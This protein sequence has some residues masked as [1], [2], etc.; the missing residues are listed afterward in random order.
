MLPRRVCFPFMGRELGGSHFS[1]RGLIRGLDRKRFEPVLVLQY[2]DG[3]V[4]EHFQNED[5]EMGISPAIPGIEPGQ[6]FGAGATLRAV[7]SARRL[8]GY[9][10]SLGVAIVH[11]N[12]GR[13]N[14]FWSLPAK[15][16]G[17]KLIWHNRGNPRSRGLRFVAPLLPDRVISVSHFASPAPGALSAAG[18]NDVIYSPFD[19]TIAVDRQKARAALAAELGVGADTPLVGYFGL[20]IDRKRPLVFVETIARLQATAPAIGLFFGDA[21]DGLAEKCAARAAE[22]G[23]ADKIR[24]M[25]FRSP[26]MQW[27]AACNVLLVTAIDEPF[28]RTLI[29][30][31]LVGTPVVA[32]A[33]GGNIEALR[34]GETGLLAPAEDADG[35]AAQAA[36]ILN[37][38]ALASSIAAEARRE[39][40][41]KFGERRHAEAVMAIYDRVLEKNQKAGAADPAASSAFPNDAA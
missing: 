20:L 14:A 11:C 1:A 19:I 5:A 4:F 7:A 22:L 32:T 36:Q 12:D 6:A 24:F 8:A 13:T 39:A 38:R 9:L 23:V 30:A 34:H 17:A 28:G 18:K 10:Q 26:G 25:G 3:P 2:A 16:A 27:I 31:M 15:L 37:D 21:Y 35:L 41:S 40:L 29:E 33:S